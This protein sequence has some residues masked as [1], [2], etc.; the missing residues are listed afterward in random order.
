[1]FLCENTTANFNICPFFSARVINVSD[2]ELQK[3]YG[4]TPQWVTWI[5][6]QLTPMNQ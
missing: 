2:R 3:D 6:E 4:K 1:M 5:S